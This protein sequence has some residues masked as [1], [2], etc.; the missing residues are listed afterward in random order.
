MALVIDSINFSLSLEGA[1]MDQLPGTV[2]VA[3][4]VHDETQPKLRM[5]GGFDYTP[6][7]TTELSATDI[8][9]IKAQVESDA[10]IT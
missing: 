9:N 10:G 1:G 5:S 6:V 3:W 4:M 7:A 2:Q 8:A